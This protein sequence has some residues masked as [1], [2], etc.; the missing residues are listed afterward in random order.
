M[1]N[2]LSPLTSSRQN[3]RVFSPASH[4]SHID[5]TTFDNFITT[6]ENPANALSSPSKLIDDVGAG[7]PQDFGYISERE[8]DTRDV[9]DEDTGFIEQQP[10]SPFQDTGRDDTADLQM[11]GKRY[12]SL[13]PS[14]PSATPR[15]RS[16][17]EVPDSRDL[18]DELEDRFKRGTAMRDVP[19]IAVN[20][21]NVD[22]SF[23][24]E[25]DIGGAAA[26][27]VGN[28]MVEERRNEGMSTV[29]HENH[30]NDHTN[31]K[32][33]L[34]ER[35]EDAMIDDS[36]HDMDETCLSTFSAVPNTDMTT[37][38]MLR[39]NS[40]IKGARPLPSS[41]RKAENLEPSTPTTARRSPKKHTL[42]DM[43][44]PVASPTPRKRDAR[45]A[46]YSNDGSN[47]LDFTD[48]LSFFPRKR[49]SVQNSDRYS[50]RRSPLRSTRESMRSPSK[51]SLLDFDIPTAPTP[52]SI[53]TVTLRELESLKSGFLSEISSLKATLSGKEAEVSSLKQAVADAE[54]R[55]GEALEEVRNEAGR[56][57]ALEV[58]QAEWERRG[59]EMEDVLRSVKAEIVEGE[60]EKER[61]MTKVDE[62]EK[63]K[64]ELESRMVELETQLDSARKATSSEEG[65]S[66]STSAT[67][68]AEQTAAE[69]QD[70]V[71]KVARELHTL[72]KGKHETK[73]AALKK[74]YEGRWEKRVR[75][76]EK[77]L[78]AVHEEN[79]RLKS[80]RDT[81]LGASARPDTSMI[82]HDKDEFEAEKRVLEAKIK[83]LQQEMAALK[84]DSDR[85]RNE[86]K[87][88]RAEKGELVA[89]VDEWLAI[90]QSQPATSENPPVFF[91]RDDASPEPGLEGAAPEEF[92]R[93]I[94]RS[95]SSGIRPSSNGSGNGEKKISKI[96]APASRHAR[97][98]SGGKSGIAVFTPGRSGIMGSIERMGRGGI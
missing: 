40:P 74:S 67:K 83:G 93:S 42:L 17:E 64:E 75:E 85:L 29:L 63:G 50:P 6:N 33:N 44:S 3:S 59:Q 84:D 12:P 31:E 48:Q 26:H 5:K 7:S 8:L 18:D 51:V 47:L 37:F 15:K 2:P 57:E 55:V 10:S 87:V 23:D 89:A 52:R 71:E 72:Y 1:S 30:D 86:L 22:A 19:D 11:L 43:S 27:E 34:R 95:A 96:G 36:Y 77:K 92:R 94:G 80:E 66:N 21:D 81:A 14:E 76:A 38:A 82:V 46:E 35:T 58:E 91:P 45:D 78:K 16:Y 97:G 32:V 69:V 88:E 73:V 39:G 61:L 54:R 41:P 13:G 25:Q 62:L 28:S 90:Q 53:P 20:D 60:R 68:T 79:E 65:S 56:K 4:A 9:F 98:N 24:N 70:A 49:Y